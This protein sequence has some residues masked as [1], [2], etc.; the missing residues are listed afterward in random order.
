MLP[1]LEFRALS[2]SAPQTRV[3]QM[4]RGGRYF[5]ATLTTLLLQF[6]NRRREAS[7]KRPGMFVVNQDGVV[8]EKDLG[9]DT[10][11]LAAG[12]SEYNPDK[13]WIRT[14]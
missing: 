11:K 3:G 1:T 6:S 7:N 2:Y 10:G 12:M 9:E 5:K 13:T 4:S 8:Y 14:D